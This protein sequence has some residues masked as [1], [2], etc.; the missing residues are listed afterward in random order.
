[1]ARLHLPLTRHLFDV[2]NLGAADHLATAL[3]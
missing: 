2:L 1:M 3:A